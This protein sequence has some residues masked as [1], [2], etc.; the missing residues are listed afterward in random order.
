M[1]LFKRGNKGTRNLTF[2]KKK[3]SAVTEQFVPVDK[4][5]ER[6]EKL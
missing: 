1:F 6:V 2:L 5:G 4:A 3:Q